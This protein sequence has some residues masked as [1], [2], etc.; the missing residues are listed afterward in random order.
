MGYTRNVSSKFTVRHL[1][2]CCFFLRLFSFFRNRNSHVVVAAQVLA[3]CSQSIHITVFCSLKEQVSQ[4]EEIRNNRVA[5]RR[6]NTISTVMC[7]VHSRLHSHQCS[8]T[9]CITD[10]FMFLALGIY[11]KVKIYRY[12]PCV[13]CCR[14]M[15]L[16]S[17]NICITLT[18]YL[19]LLRLQL[20]SLVVFK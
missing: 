3:A 4:S 19:Q 14:I 7:N 10:Q 2:S 17:C 6:C 20:E 18:I 13:M 9:F 15:M 8:P 11:V 1:F 16:H 12:L 5:Q